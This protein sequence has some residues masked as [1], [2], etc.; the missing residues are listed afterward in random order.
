MRSLSVTGGPKMPGPS[1]LF[2]LAILILAFCLHGCTNTQYQA[3]PQCQPE[4][5]PKGE[6]WVKGTPDEKLVLMTTAYIRQTQV[7]ADCNADIQ[8][9]NAANKAVDK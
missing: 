9:I 7:V 3:V 1:S 5:P 8:L 6:K 2:L 4:K